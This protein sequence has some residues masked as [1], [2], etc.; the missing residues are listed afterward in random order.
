MKYVYAIRAE[1]D[2]IKF[3]SSHDPIG[4]MKTL[5]T[6]NQAHLILAAMGRVIGMGWCYWRDSGG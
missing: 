4:R 6:G 1:M 2:A 5:Q 3:G